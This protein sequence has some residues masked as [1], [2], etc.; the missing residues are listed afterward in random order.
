MISSKFPVTKSYLS[1]KALV[2]KIEFAYALLGVKCQLLTATMRDVYLVTSSQG[3]MVFYIYRH[4]QRTKE[5]ILG[6]WHFV[7]HLFDN[8]IPVVPAIPNKDGDLVV[9]FNAP[10]GV[11]YGVLTRFVPGDHFR[12]R[13]SVESATELGQAIARI[14]VVADEMPR[15]SYRSLGDLTPQLEKYVAAFA[16]AFPERKGDVRLLHQVLDFVRPQLANLPKTKPYY[17]MIHGDVIRANVQ[18]N[19]NKQ[20]TILDFD[21]CGLGWRVYDIASF[22]ITLSGA[23]GVAFQQAYLSGYS[24]VRRL[25]SLEYDILPLFKSIRHLVAIGIPVS[26]LCYWGRA[27]IEPWF[28]IHLENLEKW[29]KQ[30][31]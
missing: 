26:N 3:K 14:H 13:P 8:G 12:R 10:E 23:N 19:D 4:D 21:L 7:S 30:M 18:V 2:H 24:S 27:N 29:I 1:A 16:V 17:G 6:E 31:V 25:D 20:V 28:D 9:E 15:Q 11:R 22:L 5:E